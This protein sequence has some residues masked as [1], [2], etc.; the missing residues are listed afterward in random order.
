MLLQR[1][2]MTLKPALAALCAAIVPLAAAAGASASQ[3][4]STALAA[5]G[6]RVAM[7]SPNW[8]AVFGHDG[9]LIASKA[10]VKKLQQ[11]GFK[12]AKSENRGCNDFAAVLESPDFSKYPVRSAF[13]LE[14]LRAGNVVS[15]APPGNAKAKPGDVNVVFGHSGS[16]AAAESLRQRVA[17]SGWRESD[18]QYA[19]PRDWT[20]VW[21][22]VP[23][24]ATDQTVQ[25]AL[26]AGLQVE[27]ELIGQ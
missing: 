22:F 2:P 6:C 7:T 4:R 13:A 14:A 12:T 17:R 23:G 1:R 8:R 5:A 21:P 11:M 18:V 10:R 3:Q 9:T 19:G 26:K 15:Y 27:L 20:V 16:L 25:S 24:S